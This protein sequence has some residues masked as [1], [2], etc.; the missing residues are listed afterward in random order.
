M[1]YGF[2]GDRS[3]SVE[4]LRFLISKGC[5]PSFLIMGTYESSSHRKELI[6][7]SGLEGSCIYDMNFVNDQKNTTTLKNYEVDY[8]FGIHF[9]YIIYDRVLSIPKIG[10]LNLHPA[11]LPYNKGW[12]TPSWAIIDKS[13][14]GATLHF[15]SKDLD[16]GDIV[17]QKE[18]K[19]D[20]GLTANQLYKNVLELEKQ[21]F[22][23]AFPEL[24]SLNPNR[25]QQVD[26]GTSYSKKDLSKMQEIDLN[27]KILPM[28]LIDKLRALTTNNIDEAA[29]FV[30]DDKKYS[31]QVNIV[32]DQI[33]NNQ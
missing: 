24:L 5:K 27:N 7:L 10:F 15:M 21:V 23:N 30:I 2:A 3:I 1:K 31:I 28:D 17:A 11:Y 16:G 8:I 19:V 12:H 33:K 25:I 4:I 32:A 29:Y 9:P 6:E 13:K 22:K 18:L 20:A 14:Y 26:K